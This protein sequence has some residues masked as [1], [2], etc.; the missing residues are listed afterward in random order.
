MEDDGDTGG[1][2]GSGTA[3]DTGATAQGVPEG[4][5]TGAA[6]AD[7]GIW[8]VLLADV[9][10]SFTVLPFEVA[11]VRLM[12][13]VVIGGVIG[14]EREWGGK[15]AGLRTHMLVSIAACLFILV[16]QELATLDYGDVTDV[17]TDPL[18]LIEAVTAGVAFLA[19]GVIFTSGGEVH[20]IKTGA[21][22]WLAGAAGLACGAGQ[23]LLAALAAGLIVAVLV[24][25]GWAERRVD[26]HEAD[27]DRGEARSAR[28]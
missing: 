15:P 6:Q 9:T 24:L 10:G 25:L 17:R 8:E 4:D 3:G 16:G 27:T 20:N 11:L 26:G 2:Q 22:M 14:F 5:A 1:G 18:R 28:R 19:A 21:S 13:A 12:A 23:M 7:L